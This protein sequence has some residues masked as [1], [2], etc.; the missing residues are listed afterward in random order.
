MGADGSNQ[1]RAT[2]NGSINKF[3]AW[4]P[5]GD[6]IVYT[7]YR[8]ENRPLLFLSTARGAAVRA[9]CCAA[10]NGD[11]AEYRGVFSPL[12]DR[13]AVVLSEPGKSAEIYTVRPDGSRLKALTRSRAIDIGPAWSPDG[14]RIA[15]VSDRS[16]SPQIYVMEADGSDVRS[17]SPSRARTTP[18]P[19]WSPDGRWIAYETRVAGQFD[20]WLIDPEG[21]VNVPLI[22]HP[23]SDES[24]AWAPNSRKLAFSS[25]RRGSRGHLRDR[26]E[27]GQ[28]AA[29][30]PEPGRGHQ[31]RPGAR[32]RAKLCGRERG[33]S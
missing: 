33:G 26:R 11:H 16:G 22:T 13:L 12:G 24:P 31:L 10:R 25:R 19:A 28:P 3:P 18:I 1:R 20:I 6:A 7:S 32:S 23:R 14:K 21:T 17:G 5:D 2:N 9:G 15:F 4:S 8:Q 27:R 30:H 29:H